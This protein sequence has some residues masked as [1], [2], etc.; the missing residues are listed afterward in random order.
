MEGTSLPSCPARGGRCFQLGNHA[1]SSTCPLFWSRSFVSVCRA[2]SSFGGTSLP[3][4]QGHIEFSSLSFKVL[5]MLP[6]SVPLSIIPAP[7]R[8]QITVTLGRPLQQE[9]RHPAII[10]HPLP[11]RVLGPAGHH[12]HTTW[13]SH[14]DRIEHHLAEVHV[15]YSSISFSSLYPPSSFIS[16]AFHSTKHILSTF[17]MEAPSRY[18]CDKYM[19]PLTGGSEMVTGFPLL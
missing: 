3:I 11:V 13:K 19:V 2:S 6:Q 16:L 7:D 9:C 8:C 18:Q 5:T 1:S 17:T 10:D 12:Q 15:N 14:S 4:H